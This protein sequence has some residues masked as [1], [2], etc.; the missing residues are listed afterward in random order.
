MARRRRHR[1]CVV[2]VGWD[3]VIGRALA[4]V[5]GLRDVTVYSVQSIGGAIEVLDDHRNC[6]VI[7]DVDS[8][9]DAIELRRR[10]IAEGH[11]GV[12]TVLVARRGDAP[13]MSDDPGVVETVAL[14][15]AEQIVRLAWRHCRVDDADDAPRDAPTREH[16]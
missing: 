8:G 5:V 2:L 14:V 16:H 9:I 1:H 4:A 6:L 11:G 7:A 15:G 13:R 3:E 12:P 10:M